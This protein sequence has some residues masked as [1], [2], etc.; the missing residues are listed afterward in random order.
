MKDLT[1]LS[2]KELFE[3]RKLANH[4][5]GLTREAQEAKA[6]NKE[7]SKRL[8]PAGKRSYRDR[9]IDKYLEERMHPNHQYGH[10]FGKHKNE[11]LSEVR[12]RFRIQNQNVKW[13]AKEVESYFRVNF[14]I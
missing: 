3:A 11:D 6:Y 13:A 14:T 5:A 12:G 10:S 8:N 7:W 1:K 9:A 4:L 2:I